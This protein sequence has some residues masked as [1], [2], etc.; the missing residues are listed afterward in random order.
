[1]K[2]I[3]VLFLISCFLL[4]IGCPQD[5]PQPKPTPRPTPKPT[6]SVLCKDAQ[7]TLESLCQADPIKNI[8]CCQVC[9][10]TKRGK[11]YTEFCEEKQEQGLS[12]NPKCVSQITA[13]DQIDACTNSN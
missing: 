8:Y 3:V 7:A 10:K 5:N 6:D 9:S 4:I 2:N 12:L 13:C 1:M 11:T